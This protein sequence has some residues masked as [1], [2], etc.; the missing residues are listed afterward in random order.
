MSSWGSSL[1]HFSLVQDTSP[2]IKLEIGMTKEF[3]KMVIYK[4]LWMI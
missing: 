2:D 3:T 4:E 1:P